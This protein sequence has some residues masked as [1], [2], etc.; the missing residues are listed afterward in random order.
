MRGGGPLGEAALTTVAT[1]AAVV[2]GRVPLPLALPRR[3]VALAATAWSHSLVPPWMTSAYERLGGG[4]VV[5]GG[6]SRGT[7]GGGWALGRLGLPEVGLGGTGGTEEK[8]V[9]R[10]TG[11]ATRRDRSE[12]ELRRS[13]ISGPMR[14][15]AV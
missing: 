11:G 14:A 12:M 2:A 3:A 9:G 7:T 10:R 5:L 13:R 4:A 8:G 1:L 6:M 15:F